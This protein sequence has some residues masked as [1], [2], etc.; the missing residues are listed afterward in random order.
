MSD[1]CTK[2]LYPINKTYVDDYVESGTVKAWEGEKVH[3]IAVDDLELTFRSEKAH[4]NV[5]FQYEK[6]PVFCYLSGR[7]GHGDK[8]FEKYNEGTNS[9]RDLERAY[10][11]WMKVSLEK[12]KNKFTGNN[13]EM[14]ER[15]GKTYGSSR[16]SQR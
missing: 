11:G 14:A 13:E 8:E 12:R 15:G 3:K 5:I 2:K 16:R 7:L 9:R 1:P 10:G 4:G 6:L